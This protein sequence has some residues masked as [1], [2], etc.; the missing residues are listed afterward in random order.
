MT[1]WE[2]VCVC[3]YFVGASLPL[4]FPSVFSASGFEHLRLTSRGE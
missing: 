3:V 1:R 2:G 4:W